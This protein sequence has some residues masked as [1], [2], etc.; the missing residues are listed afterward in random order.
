LLPGL[1]GTTRP[2]LDCH[3]G[4]SDRNRRLRMERA[5]FVN[6]TRYVLGAPV[7]STTTA[8]CDLPRTL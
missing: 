3:L 8:S 7:A 2:G 1:A 5:P 4:R 6:S